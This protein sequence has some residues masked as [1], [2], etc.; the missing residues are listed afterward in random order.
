MQVTFTRSADMADVLEHLTAYSDKTELTVKVEGPL[1][2]VFSPAT[3]MTYINDGDGKHVAWMDTTPDDQTGGWVI[4]GYDSHE[5]V[6]GPFDICDV[7]A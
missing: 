2:V 5:I 4:G 1:R 3:C 7:Q 6:D